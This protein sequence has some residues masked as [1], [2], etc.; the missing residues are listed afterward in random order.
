MKTT[1][2]TWGDKKVSTQLIYTFSSL[3]ILG[4]LIYLNINYADSI[5]LQFSINLLMMIAAF[6]FVM[7]VLRLVRNT[8]GYSS[9][10]IDE[11]NLL[12]Q[13]RS[14]FLK[15]DY[16]LHPSELKSLSILKKTKRLDFNKKNEEHYLLL[17][18]KNDDAFDVFPYSNIAFDDLKAIV[19]WIN[20][21]IS[22]SK[23]V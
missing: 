3:I 11:Q 20:Q 15:K 21:Q 5:T 19:G 16:Q 22:K 17:T 10:S 13:N 8:K 4:I 6:G 23:K 18:K 7:S 12:I 14:I 9:I 1:T 2:I